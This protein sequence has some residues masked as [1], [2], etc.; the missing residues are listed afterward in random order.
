MNAPPQTPPTMRSLVAAAACVVLF[1]AIAIGCSTAVSPPE[2]LLEISE[3]DIRGGETIR[4]TFELPAADEVIRI[5]L[6]QRLVDCVMRVESPRAELALEVN[7]PGEHSRPDTIT[8]KTP[9][10]GTYTISVRPLASP[11]VQ[12]RYALKVWRLPAKSSMER[13]VIQGELQLTAAAAQFAKGTEEGWRESLKQYI[14]AGRTFADADLRPQAANANL[15]A[16][17]VAFTKLSSWEDALRY[18]R[19]S[20]AELLAVEDLASAALAARIAASALIELA[21]ATESNGTPRSEAQRWDEAEA[22]FAQSFE[23]LERVDNPVELSLTTNQYGILHFSRRR[24]DEARAAFL[25]ARELARAENF[26]LGELKAAQNLAFIDY[27]LGN[28]EPAAESLDA[29][30]MLLE[31]TGDRVGLAI[32]LDNS[33]EVYFHLARLNESL[34][35]YFRALT[36]HRTDDDRAGEARS[37]HGIG[38][39]YLAMGDNARAL[40][41]LLQALPLRESQNDYIGLVS[42]LLA[43]GTAHERRGDTK[44]ARKFFQRA[45]SASTHSARAG[46]IAHRAQQAGAAPASCHAGA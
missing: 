25:E 31:A 12:G 23:L 8:L 41:F 19:E 1:S 42:T 26:V 33:A 38:T 21:P 22:L 13:V 28:L 11:R 18:A 14:E 30:A 4:E 16:A 27:E 45:L 39:T 3:R 10:P 7:S 46:A 20:L 2:L 29:V 36:L 34:H 9:V 5:E 35:R 17:L 24:Y 40:G 44:L 32:V 15:A 6:T 43:A 37:L